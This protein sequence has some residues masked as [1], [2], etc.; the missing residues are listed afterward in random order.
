MI[1]RKNLSDVTYDKAMRC[2]VY[3]TTVS[4]IFYGTN[5]IQCRRSS[6]LPEMVAALL[7][8][9]NMSLLRSSIIAMKT[10]YLERIF[11]K[12]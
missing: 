6:F 10:R 8:A 11:R 4:L 2:I 1:K 9:Q 5:A 3:K 12:C 7:F